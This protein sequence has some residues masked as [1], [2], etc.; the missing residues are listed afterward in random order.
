MA[1]GDGAKGVPCPT[2]GGTGR[3]KPPG[4]EDKLSSGTGSESWAFECRTNE[5]RELYAVLRGQIYDHDATWGAMGASARVTLAASAVVLGIMSISL[6]SLVALVSD[7]RL[8]GLL[9]QAETAVMTMI[10]AGCRGRRTHLPVLGATCPPC[11]PA[12]KCL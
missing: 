11:A 5:L 8:V 2:C 3:V 1:E 4:D 12:E 9:P 6:G 7:G 10:A